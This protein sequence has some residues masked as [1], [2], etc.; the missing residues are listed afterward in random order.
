MRKNEWIVTLERERVKSKK[1]A[2][3]GNR[4]IKMSQ[5]IKFEK[6]NDSWLRKYEK[7]RHEG[8]RNDNYGGQQTTKN[9]WNSTDKL[10]EN[11]ETSWAL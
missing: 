1:G 5:Q 10:W 11:F 3:E 2:W 4:K 9:E 7:A 6:V 8:L